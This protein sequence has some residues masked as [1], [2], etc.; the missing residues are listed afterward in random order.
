M[1]QRGYGRLHEQT[2]QTFRARRDA[3]ANCEANSRPLRLNECC[4]T[5]RISTAKGRIVVMRIT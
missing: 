2:Y 5:A 4:E 1:F 3:R